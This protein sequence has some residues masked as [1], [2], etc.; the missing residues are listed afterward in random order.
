MTWAGALIKII[1]SLK[2][3]EKTSHFVPLESTFAG[4][5]LMSQE[6]THLKSCGQD[7]EAFCYVN[8][9]FLWGERGT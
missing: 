2:S 6:W 7:D 5:S 8:P 1:S 3:A 9:L 4:T